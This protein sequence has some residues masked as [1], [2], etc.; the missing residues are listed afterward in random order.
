V[1]II[2]EHLKK[3]LLGGFDLE[4]SKDELALRRLWAVIDQ[5]RDVFLRPELIEGIFARK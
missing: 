1:K 4:E 2:R 5:V 3:R